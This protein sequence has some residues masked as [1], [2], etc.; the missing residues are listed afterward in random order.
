VRY[1]AKPFTVEVKRSNKRVPLTVTA[2]ASLPSKRHWQAERLLFSGLSS[3]AEPAGPVGLIRGGNL[4]TEKADLKPQAIAVEA[5]TS[6]IHVKAGRVRPTG[7]VLP[8]L[9]EQSRAE[10]R[11]CHELE[12]RAARLRAPQDARRPSLGSRPKRAKAQASAEAHAGRKAAPGPIP[13]VETASVKHPV[14][15]VN[16]VGTTVTVEPVAASSP[17]PL[18]DPRQPIGTLRGNTRRSAVQAGGHRSERREAS[19]PLRA[20]ERWKRRLPRVCW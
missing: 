20:G 7:R 9:L 13:A 2:V 14:L 17:L 11:L 15:V 4:S 16:E 19:V 1:R 5:V 8:D 18:H 12:E 10:M 3:L 6:E